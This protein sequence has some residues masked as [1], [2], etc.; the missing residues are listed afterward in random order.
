MTVTI[1]ELV[2]ALRAE[3]A[4]EA[5]KAKAAEQKLFE[6]IGDEMHAASC[7][8][9]PIQLQ[10]VELGKQAPKSMEWEVGGIDMGS[11]KFHGWAELSVGFTVTS[12]TGHTYRIAKL[13]WSGKQRQHVNSSIGGLLCPLPNDHSEAV[14]CLAKLVGQTIAT[15]TC[16]FN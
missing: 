8:L 15:G 7:A 11:N 10:L 6:Q 13:F 2:N 3:A 5:A 4:E 14:I 1:A 16:T 12:K 9:M